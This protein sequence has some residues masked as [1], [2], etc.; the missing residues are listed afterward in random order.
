MVTARDLLT[1]ARGCLD[2]AAQAERELMRTAARFCE[3]FA[4]APVTEEEFAAAT[5][6]MGPCPI[7]L[8][9]TGAP[10]VSDFAVAEFGAM[11]GWTLARTRDYLGQVLELRH[12]LPLCWATI[13][14]DQAP[15]WKARQVAEQT[16]M[17]APEVARY[18]DRHTAAGLAAS[19]FMKLQ[20]T[21]EAA[22][23]VVDDDA[24]LD[25]ITA[26]GS[27]YVDI[28]TSP[29]LD[30][31]VTRLAA[32][33]D[34]QDATDLDRAINRAVDDLGLT[35]THGGDRYALGV[36]RSKALGHLARH[37][38]TTRPTE[39]TTST[40]TSTTTTTTSTGAVKPVRTVN[41]Y[42][43]LNPTTLDG[44]AAATGL[45]ALESGFHVGIDQV[46][47]WCQASHTKVTIRPV[48]D[49]NQTLTSPGYTPTTRIRDHVQLAHPTCVFPGC[50]RTSR[51]C[52]LDH[53]VPYD[54]DGPPGQTSTTN[55]RPLCRTHHRVKTHTGW[56]PTDTDTL[57][58]TS[59][60]GL[61]I[62]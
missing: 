22:R 2:A 6:P 42:L 19:S 28:G 35:P 43:H 33:L 12:R 34:I 5:D 54:P 3:L 39:N 13:M 7:Q 61:T 38:L 30:A 10:G 46:E 47:E 15:G 53:V 60:R 59:P 27:R 8:A 31:H 23:L 45:A 14:A 18:V 32:G 24:E 4:T 20:R 62:D 17:L 9:G 1:H 55:L 48:I 58:W 41:L 49:L 52:D 36:A 40:S 44:D 50:N 26:I 16:R 56:T 21:I 29:N 25:R 51:A 37:Y 57:T 11:M